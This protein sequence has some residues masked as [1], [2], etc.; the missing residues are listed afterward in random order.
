MGKSYTN[1]V[2]IVSVLSIGKSYINFVRYCEYICGTL[3]N[4]SHDYPKLSNYKNKNS[5]NNL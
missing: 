4:G 2:L 3:S 5:I 1:F